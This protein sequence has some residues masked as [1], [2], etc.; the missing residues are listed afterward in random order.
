MRG[1]L[2]Y[3]FPRIFYSLYLIMMSSFTAPPTP[4]FGLEWGDKITHAGAFGLM[5]L[6]TFRA[7]RWLL[8]SRTLR[9]QLTV[10]VLYCMLYGA[11]D[12]IHQ[13]FVPGRQCDIFDWLA[14]S[15]GALL[16]ALFITLTIGRA[17]GR[18]LFDS[19]RD[20]PREAAR[21]AR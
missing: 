2:L 10:A 9:M 13:Y 5:M 6:A 17:L 20:S 14:D 1:F 4:T 15:T 21:E 7:V 11:S 19:P 12:E 3:L 8:R 16:G 18:V